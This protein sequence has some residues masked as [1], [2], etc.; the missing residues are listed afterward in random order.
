MAHRRQC[1][2][3]RAE[4]G[5]RVLLQRA[6]RRGQRRRPGGKQGCVALLEQ[7][8]EARTRG[9]QSRLL[10]ALAHGLCE[11]REALGA[12]LVERLG[13]VQLADEGCER[14]AFLAWVSG[15][16]TFLECAQ[17]LEH[18]LGEVDMHGLVRRREQ[19]LLGIGPVGE[20]QRDLRR[21][22]HRLARVLFGVDLRE[23]LER[24][25]KDALH[26]A[27]VARV[28]RAVEREEVAQALPQRL[29]RRRVGR[30][31]DQD[32]ALEHVVL[33]ERPGEQQLGD[34][35]AGR[36]LHLGLVV[37]EEREE[38]A[39]HLLLCKLHALRL[40]A[41][42]LGLG[43]DVG[44]P[45][46]QRLDAVHDHQVKEALHAAHLDRAG[47]ALDLVEEEREGVERHL[48]VEQR[49]EAE[50]HEALFAHHRVFAAHRRH[51]QLGYQA[52][53]RGV[54]LQRAR[55]T[56]EHRAHDQQA[57]RIECRAVRRKL[58]VALEPR[59]PRKRVRDT[60]VAVVLG[61]VR[62]ELLDEL[63]DHLHKVA[64][65]AREPQEHVEAP[66]DE[67]RR[68]PRIREHLAHKH[69]HLAAPHL[70]AVVAVDREREHLV[71]DKDARKRALVLDRGH[72]LVLL[73][74]LLLEEHAQRMVLGL[75][76]EHERGDH[77]EARVEQRLALV[78]L[79]EEHEAAREE[80][81]LGRD[82]RPVRVVLREEA[83]DTLHDARVVL[84]QGHHD[85]L[86]AVGARD[87]Q[88]A[89]QRED[90]AVGGH[91]EPVAHKL[92]CRA[93]HGRV[94]LV[95][96]GAHDLGDRVLAEAE[97]LGVAL[98]EHLERAEVHAPPVRRVD[99]LEA[100]EQVRQR[101][102]GR[103]DVEERRAAHVGAR[104][105]AQEVQEQARGARVL[106]VAPLQPRER[107]GS[108]HAH[109]GLAVGD[110]LQEEAREGIVQLV[111]G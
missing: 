2:Q 32:Q 10:G 8:F 15:A 104:V 92:A 31:V 14:L 74:R 64:L 76:A 60:C 22:D 49:A 110:A 29:I 48:L 94:A 54:V 59:M 36:G 78:R 91:L 72:I 89:E 105:V 12:A 81:R 17:A 111:A 70:V 73:A 100:L 55:H 65:P 69:K 61:E 75:D 99:V 23:D 71:H 25:H 83:R 68:K 66:R 3:K 108:L 35:L 30:E 77:W 9:A 40:V 58:R 41:F 95:Q 107:N 43:R 34:P 93:L 63:D 106:L 67:R 19:Q 33:G 101:G 50:A 96:P 82:R 102:G 38:E 21:G 37:L 86:P 44:A 6:V 109:G 46:A 39:D 84:E 1:V 20:L 16:R 103:R 18:R 42:E 90:V 57:A 85:R 4:I 98:D 56:L 24:V 45:A 87:V 28:R 52:V 88:Q 5:E 11:D 47:A 26:H 51:D 97:A 7:G 79:A 13:E 27:L 53:E 62:V 80:R